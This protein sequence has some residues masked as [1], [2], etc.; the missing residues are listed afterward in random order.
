[1]DEF[2]SRY[3]RWGEKDLMMDRTSEEDKRKD[4][5]EVTGMRT[6]LNSDTIWVAWNYER[7][8]YMICR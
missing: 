1:L 2:D 8:I 6:C 3:W 4:D 7:V 5:F